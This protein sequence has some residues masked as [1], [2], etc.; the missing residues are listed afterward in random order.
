MG[1][2]AKLPRTREEVR[3]KFY[4]ERA[5]SLFFFFFLAG[6]KSIRLYTLGL[7]TNPETTRARMSQCC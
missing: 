5:V 1:F 6:P 2:H 3:I 7:S 4:M